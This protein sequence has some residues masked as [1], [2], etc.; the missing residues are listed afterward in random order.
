VNFERMRAE[1][2]RRKV[3]IWADL[4]SRVTEHITA[5]GK[6]AFDLLV[7]DE[8]QDAGIAELRFLA[9]IGS[10]RAERP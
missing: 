6:S 10:S 8:A 5:R 2:A 3:V 4:F 7:V 9:A 1:L